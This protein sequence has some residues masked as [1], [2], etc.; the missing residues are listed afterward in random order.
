MELKSSQT[1][2]LHQRVRDTDDSD[3]LEDRGVA[4]SLNIDHSSD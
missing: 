4:C 1:L 2:H 3:I